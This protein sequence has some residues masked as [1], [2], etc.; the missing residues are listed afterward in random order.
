MSASSRFAAC[1][2]T[3]A[4]ALAFVGCDA[5]VRPDCQ[6]VMWDGGQAPPEEGAPI[7][8]DVQPIVGPTDIDWSASR[9][10]DGNVG[11][12]VLTLRLQPAAAERMAEHTRNNVGDYMPVGLNGNVLVVPI[13]NSPIEGGEVA[14]E[15]SVDGA[16]SFGPLRSCVGG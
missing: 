6:L 2:L 11:P 5:A 7:P 8:A 3:V 13:I 4:C 1:M 9:L 16:A 10:D 12:P 14:L 15:P